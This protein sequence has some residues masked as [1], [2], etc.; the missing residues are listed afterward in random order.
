[1]RGQDPQRVALQGAHGSG[2]FIGNRNALKHGDYTREAFAARKASR[3][4]LEEIRSAL[5]AG[6]GVELM[7][8]AAR[9]R[10]RKAAD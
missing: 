8:D 9:R 7:W 1:M 4:E 10:F 5:L 2:A 6:E 3:L